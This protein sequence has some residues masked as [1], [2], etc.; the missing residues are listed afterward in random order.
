MTNNKTRLPALPRRTAFRNGF[1]LLTKNEDPNNMFHKNKNKTKLEVWKNW[2]FTGFR[3]RRF[4][5]K[6]VVA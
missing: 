1:T 6:R 3:F 5:S 4:V 2:C